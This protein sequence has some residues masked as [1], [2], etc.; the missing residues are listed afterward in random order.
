MKPII[1]TQ[2][3]VGSVLLK[4][5][6]LFP[7]QFAIRV[8]VSFSDFREDS[9]LINLIVSIILISLAVWHT[10][11]K[12]DIRN[13]T[14]GKTTTVFSSVFLFLG[15]IIVAGIPVINGDP[16]FSDP[17]VISFLRWLFVVAVVHYVV[18]KVMVV[19]LVNINK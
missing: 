14:A 11:I 1:S 3:F 17:L 5:I 18:L 19:R 13:I 4:Y 15:A 12:S 2:Q 9:I 6:L 7:I 10:C 8:A 16:I